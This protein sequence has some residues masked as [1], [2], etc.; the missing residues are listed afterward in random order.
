ML[1]MP[2]LAQS[3][4]S[5]VTAAMLF[6]PAH[7]ALAAVPDAA[8]DDAALLS[9]E[10]GEGAEKPAG[11]DAAAKDKAPAK[12]QGGF[13]L[14]PRWRVHYDVGKVSVP[15]TVAM[16]ERGWND[17]LRRAYVGVDAKFGGGLSSRV[18]L[19]LSGDNPEFT[20]LYLSYEK[21]GFTV[22]AGQQKVF[23]SL[24]DMTSD[25]HLSFAERAA[26]V[27]AF[28]FGRRVGV[29]ASVKKGDFLVQGGVSTD[30]LVALNDVKNNS[31][32]VNG[33]VVWAPKMGDTQ[34]HLGASA[35]WRDRKDFADIA[36]RYRVRPYTRTI[37]T[38]FLSTPSLKV[39]SEVGFGAE[40]AVIRGRLHGAA[41]AYW[42][43][44]DLARGAVYRDPKMWGGYA[45]VGLFLTKD[46]RS[47]KGGNF[48]AV[49]PS[50]PLGSGG[51][52][53]VQLN[54][55]YDYL[56]M[57]KG[58][59]AGEVPLAPSWGQQRALLGSLI[60]TPIDNVAFSMNY[61]KS[62]YEDAVIA[63]LDGDRDYS[64]ETWLFRFQ[65]QY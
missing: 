35:S 26:F 44:P 54:A 8:P 4:K 39:K 24:D 38:R 18:E 22:T 2:R 45:E 37:G 13:Q 19:D 63:A 49:K 10:S 14:K 31:L 11:Q 42:L 60:W 7:M 1:P 5:G 56:D 52:G 34:V 6:C 43:R 9:E 47:Y 61:A 48:G 36:Q 55:R 46:T 17:T 20:D 40:A 30:T 65:L 41:E 33:R 3:L 58:F 50:A 15:A 64:A 29:T 32:G 53:A 23:Q 28:G 25:L 12:E 57:G 16:P 21:S 62:R 27:E 51:I 59:S